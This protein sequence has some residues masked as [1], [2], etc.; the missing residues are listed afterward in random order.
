MKIIIWLLLLLPPQILAFQTTS[1]RLSRPLQIPPHRVRA[2][3]NSIVHEV[4]EFSPLANL[5]PFTSWIPA[6]WSE[7]VAL[8]AGFGNHLELG[9]LGVLVASCALLPNAVQI[10]HRGLERVRRRETKEGLYKSTKTFHLANHVRQGL[11]GSA[12]FLFLHMV[13]DVLMKRLSVPIKLPIV[14]TMSSDFAAIYFTVLSMV[15]VRWA[16]NALLTRFLRSEAEVV[17]GAQAVTN[18]GLY[19]VTAVLITE[20]LSAAFQIRSGRII[21]TLM[22]FGGVGTIAVALASQDIAAGI[23]SGVQLS[24]FKP[25]LA[26]DHLEGYGKV[27]KINLFTTSVRGDDEISVEIPNSQI[28]NEKIVNLSRTSNSQVTQKLRYHTNVVDK[29]PELV[30]AIRAEIVASCPE[31]ISDGSRPFRVH[32]SGIG[33]GHVEVEVDCRFRVSP[34]SDAYCEVR[35]ELLGALARASKACGAAFA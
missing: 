11:V 21:N 28:E 10:V 5:F 15:R 18:L 30:A 1:L 24:L 4:A 20:H 8:L 35:Q 29:M 13:S 7:R 9:A 25:F 23:L 14:K 34:G 17:S 32:W 2:V 16:K 22:G 27:E 3:P 19:I 33:E 31:L 6:L 26:G 12:I